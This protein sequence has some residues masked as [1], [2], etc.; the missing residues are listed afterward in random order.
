VRLGAAQRGEKRTSSS[1]TSTFGAV[2]CDPA[3]DGAAGALAMAQEGGEPAQSAAKVSVGRL[4]VMVHPVRGK[5]S[6]LLPEAER[7]QWRPLHS[8]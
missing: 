4:G 5:L 3:V 2:E 1:H 6:A 8:E 7:E